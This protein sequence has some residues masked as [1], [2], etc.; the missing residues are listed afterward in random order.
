[1]IPRQRSAIEFA[2]C[3]C[4]WIEP[5]IIQM[6]K[7]R[8]M[9]Y[10]IATST[11]THTWARTH[12]CTIRIVLVQSVSR[13]SVPFSIQRF[14][15]YSRYVCEQK[16]LLLFSALVRSCR[17]YRIFIHDN[18]TVRLFRFHQSTG[19]PLPRSCPTSPTSVYLLACLECE[20]V[21]V[22]CA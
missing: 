12:V 21:Y 16:T 20:S 17:F 10:A 19:R 22:A 7:I 9:A 13:L 2:V 3:V 4:V 8:Y 5:R 1:M 6:R 18:S 14:S 15:R 11:H